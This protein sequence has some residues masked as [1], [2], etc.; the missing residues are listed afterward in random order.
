MIKTKT[1]IA[2]LSDV[3]REW[4]F[5]FYLKL[6]EKLTGQD[7]RLKSPF[8]VKDNTPSAFVYYSRSLQ[9]Y[10]F[11][12]FSSGIGGD[13]VTLV[14]ALFNLQD[15]GET[16]HKIICDYNEFILN[17]EEGYIPGE[18]KIQQKYRVTNHQIRGWNN[19]DQKYWSQY[20][21]G[22]K[23]LNN[24][25]VKGLESY[26]MAKEID[27]DLK[28]LLIKG[29]HIYGYFR[30]DG[31]LYKIY[32]PMIREMKFINIKEYIHG[33]DQLTYSTPYLLICSSLKDMMAFMKLNYTGIEVVA[34]A[35]ENTMIS[36]HIISAYKLKYKKVCTLFDYDTA[37]MKAMDKYQNQHELNKIVLQLSK[38]LSDSIKDYGIIKV[39]EVLTPLLKQAFK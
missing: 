15:R 9:R 25:N 8:N 36:P 2:K 28:E 24:Y 6:G 1:L 13:G 3:P 34:P 22:S 12:D 7:V 37:G 18:F 19:L 16:A 33:T 17:N 23:L 5:E 35:S 27:G 39:R 21:I 4:V 11:K 31:S 10:A 14:K 26:T 38:D 20:N 29:Q 30:T 32:Q